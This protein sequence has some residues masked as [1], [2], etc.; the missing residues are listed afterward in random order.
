MAEGAELEHSV[1]SLP[2]SAWQ[3]TKCCARNLHETA[4]TFTYIPSQR[5]ECL[6]KNIKGLDYCF[7][8]EPG[9]KPWKVLRT[10]KLLFYLLGS[11]VPIV[12]TWTFLFL[13][14]GSSDAKLTELGLSICL[15]MTMFF[16]CAFINIDAFVLRLM[17]VVALFDAISLVTV[18]VLLALYG[19][20]FSLFGAVYFVGTFLAA[21]TFEAVEVD[22]RL[23]MRRE[24]RFA[25]RVRQVLFVF[26]LTSTVVFR[27]SIFLK[28]VTVSNDIVIVDLGNASESFS[29]RDIWEFLVDVIIVRVTYIGLSRLRQPPNSI[30]IG[31]SYAILDFEALT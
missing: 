25:Y 17:S 4:Q 31:R 13:E 26:L 5:N 1:A 20:G 9:S 12:G 18:V 23:N 6:V 29:L 24:S 16:S 30:E 14:V 11:V 8:A 28:Q 3:D 19:E 2:V 21:Y 27:T 22:T 10:V 7:Y 15:G